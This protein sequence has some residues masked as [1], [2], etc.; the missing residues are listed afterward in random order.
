MQ[1][2][3]IL[4]EFYFDT[5]PGDNQILNTVQICMSSC[6]KKRTHSYASVFS[7]LK[8]TTRFELVMTVLQTGALPLG[9]VAILTFVK[10]APRVGLEPTTPRLTAVCSTIELSRNDRKDITYVISSSSVPYL[11]Y[12][13]CI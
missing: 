1:K 7:F 3:E 13:L 5:I 2:F 11:Y 9:Y 6:K 4:H 12:I 8:A 10:Q